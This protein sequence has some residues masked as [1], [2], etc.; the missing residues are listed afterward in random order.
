M[1]ITV[2]SYVPGADTDTGPLRALQHSEYVFAVSLTP[3]AKADRHTHPAAVFRAERVFRVCAF[4][5]VCVCVCLCVCVCVCVCVQSGT[6]AEKRTDIPMPCADR[7]SY[8]RMYET[9]VSPES[10]GMPT[11]ALLRLC[12]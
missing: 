2:F 4:V 8:G 12:Y 1:R 9:V 6:E 7:R 11:E 10:A 5:C 3:H